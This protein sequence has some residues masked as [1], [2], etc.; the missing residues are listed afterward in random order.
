MLSESQSGIGFSEEEL[1]ELDEKVSSLIRQGQSHHNISVH[2]R[3]YLMVSEAT[4]YRLV[5]SGLIAA[6][7]LALPRKVRFK[8]RKRKSQYLK[9]T[10]HAGLT[11]IMRTFAALWMRIPICRWSRWT[12]LKGKKVAKFF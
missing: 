12:L 11:G 6:R 8:A 5:E 2:N 4:T 7:N 1:R 10:G 3:D 9:W